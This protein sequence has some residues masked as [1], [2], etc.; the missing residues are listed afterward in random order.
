MKY[1]K[2]VFANVKAEKVYDILSGHEDGW[3]FAPGPAVTKP[4]LFSRQWFREQKFKKIM[5]MA[6]CRPV[7]T[8][9]MRYARHRA[10]MD[11]WMLSD[12]GGTLI[13]SLTAFFEKHPDF[14][15]HE[16]ESQ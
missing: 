5:K 7:I 4:R 13:I 3:F 8:N 16:K 9:E 6:G 14:E 2:I 15:A 10:H 1:R 12:A 11:N